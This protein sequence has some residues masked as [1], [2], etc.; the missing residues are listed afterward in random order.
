MRR[1]A[2]MRILSRTFG[3]L[4]LSGA[5]VSCGQTRVPPAFEDN[6]PAWLAGCRS[7][8]ALGGTGYG[9]GFA[10][11]AER[12]A[13]DPAYRVAWDAGYGACIRDVYA[14]R[15]G[16]PGGGEDGAAR[17]GGSLPA[18]KSGPGDRGGGTPAAKSPGRGGG[19]GGGGMAAGH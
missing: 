15:I 9:R 6:R 19:G 8:H 5:L 16:G 2:M 17:R 12:Y 10:R 3:L 18:A 4:V 7:G 13:D 1:R 11:D 14:R